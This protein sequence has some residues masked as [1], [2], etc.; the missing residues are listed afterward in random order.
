MEKPVIA[1]DLELTDRS[2]QRIAALCARYP[3]RQSAL[4][5]CLW[6][7]QDEH[8]WVPA[9]AVPYLVDALGV[10][11]ARVHELLTFYTMF[12]TEKPAKYVLQVCRNISCHLLGAREVIAHLEKRLGIRLGET[13]PDGRFALAGV[14]CLGA[15]G[16]G[17]VLQL[18]KHFYEQLT[19]AR[20]DAILESLRRDVVPRADTDRLFEEDR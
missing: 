5:P 12:R 10:S 15:C 6:V 7:I 2:R 17:P 3:T 20:V 18:G 13:T 9:A 14:E 19:P 4:M 16:H 8:G 11:E 1:T